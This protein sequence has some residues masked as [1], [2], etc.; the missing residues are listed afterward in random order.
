MP[1]CDAASISITSSDVPAAIAEADAARA[2]R[3]G[4]RPVH[5]VEALRED[6]RHRRLAGAARAGEE[7]GLAHLLRRDRVLQRAD[8]RLLADDLVEGL[9]TVLPVERGHGTI[10]AGPGRLPRSAVRARAASARRASRRAHFVW[11]SKRTVANGSE[12]Q[13]LGPEPEHGPGGRRRRAH[14]GDEAPALVHEPVD[15]EELRRAVLDD[16][17]RERRAAPAIA[18]SRRE[19]GNRV[20]SSAAAAPRRAT[21]RVERHDRE[22]AVPDAAEA[23]DRRGEVAVPDPRRASAACRRSA[24]TARR[25]SRRPSPRPR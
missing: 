7:I 16:E 8:D 24:A 23:D 20:A 14:R 15:A 1:R 11:S 19:T 21:K 10:Q 13:A 9:R 3:L 5:A 2:V 4:R 18:R 12:Q 25:S 6:A 17:P 22:P